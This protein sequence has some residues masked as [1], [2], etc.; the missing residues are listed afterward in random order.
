MT[1]VVGVVGLGNM[2][3]AIAQTLTRNGFPIVGCD[4]SL[5]RRSAVSREFGI[6]S[7]AS[8]DMLP[9]PRTIVL[10]L[11]TPAISRSVIAMAGRTCGEGTTII[12]TST[13]GPADMRS[14]ADVCAEFRMSIIDSAV[15]AGVEQMVA[16]RATL[17][18]GGDEEIISE[19]LPILEGFSAKQISF[20]ELGSGMAAKLVNNAVAHALMSVLVEAGALA[21]AAGL[22]TDDLLRLLTD[23]EMGIHRPLRARYATRVRQRDYRG[24]MPISAARKDSEL[25]L[26]LAQ[27]HKVPLFAIQAAQSVFDMAEASGLGGLDYSSIAQLWERWGVPAADDAAP[28]NE[29]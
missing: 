27:T 1:D 9:A 24:G 12:E 26:Q 28:R 20:G 4:S 29:P 25:V 21:T 8:A 17:L 16:G 14:A 3:S 15:L 13:V 10:S 2:G 11:P 6:S 22:S 7:V 5:E 23:E 18:L 19:V